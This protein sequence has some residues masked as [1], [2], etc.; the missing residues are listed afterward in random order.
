MSE[1]GDNSIQRVTDVGEYPAKC[2]YGLEEKPRRLHRRFVLR[3]AVNGAIRLL[4]ID[5][6]PHNLP[7]LVTPNYYIHNR[8]VDADQW[9]VT[10]E[11]AAHILDQIV[12]ES[13]RVERLKEEEIKR[14]EEELK[15]EQE[16]IIAIAAAKAAAKAAKQKEKQMLIASGLWNKSQYKSLKEAYADGWHER[17][18]DEIGGEEITI[19]GHT[20][21]R[22]TTMQLYVYKSTIREKYGLTSSMIEE[23]GQPDKH[24]PNQHYRSGPPASLY[25]VERVESW[26]EKNLERIKA[27][28]KRRAKSKIEKLAV[29]DSA[30]LF[31][32]PFDYLNPLKTFEEPLRDL[33]TPE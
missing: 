5:G 33:E 6:N 7:E 21:V 31:K 19:K 12:L 10:H 23:L 13:V 30:K 25:K 3:L 18:E 2:F 8:K 11:D 29:T 22:N 28:E 14:K 16:E 20:L 15:R 1:N 24:V 26:I 9:Y 27:I 4:D 32:E 17:K